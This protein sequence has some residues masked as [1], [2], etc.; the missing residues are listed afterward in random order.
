[1]LQKAAYFVNCTV[2]ED[3]ALH[4]P[5]TLKICVD[6]HDTGWHYASQQPP[7]AWC[8]PQAT[9]NS[10]L[11]LQALW[12]ACVTLCDQTPVLPF[13]HPPLRQI[14]TAILAL[15]QLKC[16]LGT[17]L[18]PDFQTSAKRNH[19]HRSTKAIFSSTVHFTCKN[20]I[21]A[22]IPACF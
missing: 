4:P 5:K 15:T 10:L 21:M 7:A 13:S 1:M 20:F 8:S 11:L 18:T 17:V 12:P 9:H 2:P 3:Q 16:W 6:P 19:S 22:L 14:Y